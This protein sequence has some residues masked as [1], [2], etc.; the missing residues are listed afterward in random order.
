MAKVWSY[1]EVLKPRETS[2]LVFIGLCAAIV[3]VQD[4]PPL[5]RLLLT[6]VAITLGSGGVNGLTNY[7]DRE[8]DSRMQRTRNRCLASKRIDPPEKALLFTISLTV[9][10]LGLALYLHPL[11]FV[12]GLIGT[13]TAVIK[14]KTVLCPFLGAISSCGPVLIAWFAF[15][16]EFDLPLLLLCILIWVWVPLHIWSAMLANRDDYRGGG[17]KYFPLNRDVKEVVIVLPLLSLLLLT[18]SVAI[19]FSSGDLG[20][21]YLIVAGLLGILMVYANSRLLVS[22][23]SRDAWRVYKLSA[24]PYLGLIFLTMCLDSWLI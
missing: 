11:C 24:F 8:I 13:L 1:I 15:K 19:Y 5:G 3:A 23:I 6:V 17:V 2:L 9:V 22:G 12:A 21:L 16:P 10:A 4:F 20:V 18:A 14:R 7:I